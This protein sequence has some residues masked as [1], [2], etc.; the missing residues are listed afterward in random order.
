[1]EKKK[2]VWT[3]KLIVN[4]SF[5][6]YS[7]IEILFFPSLKCD[8]LNFC[9]QLAIVVPTMYCTTVLLGGMLDAA[10]WCSF[11]CLVFN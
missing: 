1:M 6:V 8:L 9:C 4:M 2:E 3:S 10:K 7:M 11:G 5:V